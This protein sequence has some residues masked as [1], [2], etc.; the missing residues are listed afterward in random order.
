MPK[1]N[2]PKNLLMQNRE[3]KEEIL[4]IIYNNYYKKKIKIVLS[5]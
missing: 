3:F 2:T 1:L 4:Q 5:N